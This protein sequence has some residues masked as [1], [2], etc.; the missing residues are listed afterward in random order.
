MVET[1]LMSKEEK[2][3]M[4]NLMMVLSTKQGPIG[5]EVYDMV[6]SFITYH[7]IFMAPGYG[8]GEESLWR[9][10]ED[11]GKDCDDQ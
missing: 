4:W 7:G 11:K 5:L 3:F 2:R 8:L 6:R 1:T 9:R 10:Q